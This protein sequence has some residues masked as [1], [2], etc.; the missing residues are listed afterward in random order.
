M[1]RRKFFYLFFS[2]LLAFCSIFPVLAQDKVFTPE[3]VLTI[4]NIVD[5]QISP[6]GANIAF[7]V[8]RPRTDAEG[9]GTAISEI[10]M[11]LKGGQ[12]T[13]FTYNEKSD[14]A[15]QWAKDG[16]S[17]AFLSQRGTVAQTQIYQIS[18]DGGE[19]QRI[20]KTTASI[21]NFKWSPDG[22][23]IAFLMTDVKSADEL[24]NEKEGKDWVVAD[25]NYKHTRLYLLDPKTGEHK[26]VTQ[27]DMTVH[28]FDWSPDGKE[29]ILAASDTP[30]IDDQFMKSKLL[31]Q[32]VDGG[33]AKLLVKTEGKLLSPRW[34]PDGKWVSWL[35][36]VSFN[37]PFAGSVFVVSS[38]GGAAENLVPGF[39][40]SA[41]SLSWLAPSTVVF[42]AT[43]RQVSTLTTITL[44]AKAKTVVNNQELAFSSNPSFTSDGKTWVIAANTPKHP[45][46]IFISE[47][48]SKQ[49]NKLTNFN[50]QLAGLKLGEQE[51]IKWKSSVDGLDIEG[52]IVKPVGFEKGKR[53]PLV[54]QPHGGPEA[55]ELNGWFGSYSRWGQVLAG[56]GYIT[57]YPNY[58]GSIGRGVDFSKADHRDLMGKEFQDMV[59]GVDYLVSQGMVDQNRVGVGGG[60]YGGYTSAW[61]ATAGSKRFKAA[62]AW[63][64]IS[65]W[66]SMTGTCEIF[67]ENSTVHWD[68]MM[69][70]NYQI[71]FDRS[72]IAHVKNANTATLIIHGA[73]DTRVPIGQSQELYTALKYKGVPVEFVTYPREGHGVGEKAHQYDFMQRVFGWFDKYLQ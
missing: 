54:M 40:G 16:K 45:N 12:P 25:K 20:S 24:K 22:N 59:D 63:M 15:I 66:H 68:L 69:Y 67:L 32:S 53:Y 70:D 17:F 43:E 72:P 41:T 26:L 28:D 57:F 37:D 39:I 29:L 2:V 55:A 5:A 3:T 30:T 61:A 35:G 18:L 23:K 27:K 60:S 50:P 48:T 1:T 51:V 21:N 34:S 33:D 73:Q 4:R 13:R 6:D 64:G 44:P 42:T 19:A 9:P 31:V 11:M 62:I 46:E 7:Q 10:W 38:Q 8:S 58:R 36:A 47:L 49:A 71:Y 65:N 56:K 52:V 14:R